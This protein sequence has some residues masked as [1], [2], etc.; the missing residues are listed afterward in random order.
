MKEFLRESDGHDFWHGLSCRRM[1]T[2]DG[3]EK[4]EAQKRGFREKG[5]IWVESATAGCEE[6]VL[7]VRV[8]YVHG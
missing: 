7:A 2:S 8:A 4:W 1:R 3:K 6:Q 5:T